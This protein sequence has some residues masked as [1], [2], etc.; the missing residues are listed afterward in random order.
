[1]AF[2]AIVLATVVVAS[3]RASSPVEWLGSLAVELTFGHASVSFRL[4]EAEAN[5]SEIVVECH[6]KARWY[7]LGKEAAWLAY[8][9]LLG[10]W[11]PIVGV[12]VFLLYPWWRRT[13]TRSRIAR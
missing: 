5:R 1:M 10:A 4:A 7:F 11:S 12:V 13:W 3:G 6:E 8:F 9:A 2:V